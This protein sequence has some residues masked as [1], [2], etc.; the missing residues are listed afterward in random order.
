MCECYYATRYRRDSEI[1]SVIFSP[2]YVSLSKYKALD[3]TRFSTKLY[4]YFSMKTYVVVTH[5]KCLTKALQM[6]T[7][8]I[9]FHVEI[10]KGFT[11]TPSYLELCQIKNKFT[12][13]VTSM[14]QDQPAY[15][16]SLI[17]VCTGH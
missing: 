9:C 15:P 5:L 17:R 2:K 3:K 14:E 4:S 13:F 7:H 6:S 16:H 10:R 12:T 1:F 11:D 8:N